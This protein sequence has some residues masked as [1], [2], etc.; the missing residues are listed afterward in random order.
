MDLARLRDLY[1]HLTL[2]QRQHLDWIVEA[3]SRPLNTRVLEDLIR[4][5]LARRDGNKVVATEDGRYVALLRAR[6]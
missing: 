3:G 4:L 6:L 2:A 5:G 1:F